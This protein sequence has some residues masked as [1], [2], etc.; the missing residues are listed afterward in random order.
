MS[1]D[2]DR[3]PSTEP[4]IW[5][6]EGEIN[7]KTQEALNVLWHECRRQ[8][9][10]RRRAREAKAPAEDRSAERAKSHLKLVT[11]D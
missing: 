6:F 2:K 11:K 5:S 10:L 3:L 8:A 9:H 4:G 1:R 7:P